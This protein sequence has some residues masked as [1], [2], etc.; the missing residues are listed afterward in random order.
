MVSIAASR[1]RSNPRS[2]DSPVTKLDARVRQQTGR[3]SSFERV[4]QHQAPEATTAEED[5]KK[6]GSTSR[7]RSV[8]SANQPAV[9]P[10]ISRRSSAENRWSIPNRGQRAMRR[11]LP[12]LAVRLLARINPAILTQFHAC[13]AV[14]VLQ[15]PSIRAY[16]GERRT[17]PVCHRTK[18]VSCGW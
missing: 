8:S 16:L 10:M 4:Q 13:P 14:R 18:A 5:L 15:V 6:R 9:Q 7:E 3:S 11:C 2:A 12:L 17:R 1:Q